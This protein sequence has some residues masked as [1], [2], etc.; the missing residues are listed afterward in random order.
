MGPSAP[1]HVLI[2]EDNL[3]IASDAE[4]MVLQAGA[5]SVDLAAS[6]EQAFAAI[7]LRPPAFAFLDVDLGKETSFPIAD[8]LRQLGI[9][10]AFLTG[11]DTDDEFPASHRGSPRIGKPYDFDTLTRAMADSSVPDAVCAGSD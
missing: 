5:T 2:V 11:Y 10:Y 7:A 6:V 1:D 8:K 3:I 4:C 9:R